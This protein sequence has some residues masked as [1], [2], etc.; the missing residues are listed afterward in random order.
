MKPANIFISLFISLISSCVFAG[1]PGDKTSQIQGIIESQGEGA[2]FVTVYA[3]GSHDG[4]ATAEDGSYLL[5]LPPGKHQIRVQ[6]IGY[7][8]IEHE[9]G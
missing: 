6:G 4:T 5:Q 8:A 7:K 9:I 1:L 2:S 3:K